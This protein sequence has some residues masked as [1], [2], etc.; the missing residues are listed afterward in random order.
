[1][2]LP[3]LDP[4]DERFTG[5]VAIHPEGPNRVAIGAAG[6]FHIDWGDGSQEC[7]SSPVPEQAWWSYTTFRQQPTAELLLEDLPGDSLVWLNRQP[8][9][10]AIR[11]GGLS[12]L[13]P[14]SRYRLERR[15]DN[16]VWLLLDPP[17]WPE[18]FTYSLQIRWRY[19]TAALVPAIVRHDYDHAN[20]HLQG[21]ETS[22]GFRQAIVSLT[23]QSGHRLTA[24]TLQDGEA[25]PPSSSAWLEV[26]VASPVLSELC[27]GNRG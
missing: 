11:D 14:A 5:L 8:E 13:L 25:Y 1:L 22:W 6:S 27:L 17:L 23:P 2:P 16:R 21:S 26:A 12:G 10:I 4:Q 7:V 15:D 19:S 24:L 9:T 20:P 3:L 18:G